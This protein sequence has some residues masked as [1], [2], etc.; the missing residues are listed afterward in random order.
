MCCN[1]PSSIISAAKRPAPVA[2]RAGVH[3]ASAAQSPAAPRAAL[4]L[5]TPVFEYV[6]STALT[7]VSPLTHKVYR[8]EKQG[9]RAEV[10][11]R[12]RSWIAF[13]PSLVPAE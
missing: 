7:V 12:D 13:V 1:R 4:A 10:D 8:F 5:A 6:G 3:T 9:A 2:P 11:H